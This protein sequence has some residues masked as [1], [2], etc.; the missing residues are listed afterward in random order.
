[1][2]GHVAALSAAALVNSNIHKDSAGFHFLQVFLFEELRGASAGNQDRTDDQVSVFH[3]ALNVAVR[4]NQRLDMGAEH[5]VQ[6]FQPLQVHVQDGNVGTHTHSNL[7]SVHPNSSPAEDNHIGFRGSG[8]TGQQDAFPAETLFQVLRAFL[9]GKAAGDLGHRSQAGQGAVCFLDGLVGNRLDLALQEGIHLFLVSCQMKVSVKN[10]TVM[11]KGIFLFQR[12]LNL[13]HHIN[14]MPDIRRVIDQRRT[15]VH[16]F[17]VRET[18]TNPGSLFHVN[19]V[20]GSH[21][22]FN[23]VRRQADTEFVILDL[24][25]TADLHSDCS[26]LNNFCCLTSCI[27]GE[28]FDLTSSLARMASYCLEL[29]FVQSI[30]QLASWYVGRICFRTA[31]TSLWLSRQSWSSSRIVST[32]VHSTLSCFVI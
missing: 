5:I 6:L 25:N 23:I 16:I 9:D 32:S 3:N 8:N 4:G 15:R 28:F 7:A 27:T 2:G 18:G 22:R 19:M 31:L 20:A 26:P 1:M 30:I 10:Q 21:I 11:E 24:F 12:F 29:V 17:I 13:D 14:Q